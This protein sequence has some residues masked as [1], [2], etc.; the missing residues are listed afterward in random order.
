M[1]HIFLITSAEGQGYVIYL[2]LLLRIF[3]HR[4]ISTCCEWFLKKLWMGGS[5]P[6]IFCDELNLG[7]EVKSLGSDLNCQCASSY[8]L[9][10]VFVVVQV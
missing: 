2:C 10:C 1:S 8:A 3:V 7:P 6:K 4:I 5:L 9:H